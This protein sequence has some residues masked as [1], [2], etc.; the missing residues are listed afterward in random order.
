MALVSSIGGETFEGRGCG[1]SRS[2]ISF[3]VRFNQFLE[4]CYLLRHLCVID[5]AVQVT[6]M[7]KEKLILEF[8]SRQ[9]KDRVMAEFL[10]CIEFATA[11]KSC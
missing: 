6:I 9:V 3:P 1:R 5:N 11:S 4:C 10:E 2:V 8:E 7:R